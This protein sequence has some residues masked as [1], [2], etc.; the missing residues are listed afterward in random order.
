MFFRVCLLND[1]GWHSHRLGFQLIIL[2]SSLIFIMR[3]SHKGLLGVWLIY[4][5]VAGV[6]VVLFEVTLCIFSVCTLPSISAESDT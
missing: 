5:I 2:F 3:G 4:L 6:K 1:V